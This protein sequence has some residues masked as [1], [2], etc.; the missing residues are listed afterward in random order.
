MPTYS[1][2]S[3]LQT[4][5]P[6]LARTRVAV[7]AF[8]FEVLTEPANTPNHDARVAWA[9]KVTGERLQGKYAQLVLDLALVGNEAFA[10]AGEAATDQQ[11]E[12]LVSAY[13]P[14]MA[15]IGL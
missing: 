13:L 5:G 11:I 1:E 12:T 10:T 15:R 8:L 3:L 14:E 4:S 2:I 7:T 6:L 9:A